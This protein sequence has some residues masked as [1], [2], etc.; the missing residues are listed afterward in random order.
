M[1]RSFFLMTSLLLGWSHISLGSVE[2]TGRQIF[3]IYSSI[4]AVEGEYMFL[5]TNTDTVAAES[6]IKIMLPEETIDWTVGRGI[7]ADDIIPG[8]D[9]GV[10][11]RKNVEPG[12]DILI[13]LRFKASA[14][15]GSTRLTWKPVNE[16]AS[17]SVFVRKG[18][19]RAIGEG[20]TRKSERFFG[21]NFDTI[22][23][24]SIIAGEEISVQVSGLAEGRYRY[25][26]VGVVVAALLVIFSAMLTWKTRPAEKDL[27]TI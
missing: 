19:V 15:L 27:K 25:W 20:F 24:S 16:V 4:D 9:G 18:D 11:L 23:R 5:V 12:K 6:N 3:L 21:D 1:I 2:I 8:K 22:T 7:V 17:L 26:V 10:Y 13:S 14:Q